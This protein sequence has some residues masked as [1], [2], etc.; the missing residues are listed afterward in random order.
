MFVKQP[1]VSAFHVYQE[2]LVKSHL[3]SEFYGLCLE[4]NYINEILG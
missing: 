3:L 1:S 2:T 4:D